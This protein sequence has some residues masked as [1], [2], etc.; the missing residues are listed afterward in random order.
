MLNLSKPTRIHIVGI[1]GAGMSA[2]AVVL[3]S[4]GHEV[5]GSD[6]KDSPGMDRL[7]SLGVKVFVGH[8]QDQ[9]GQ[10]DLVAISS[11]IPD[12]NVEIL[13][14]HSRSIPVLKRAKVLAAISASK[15]TIAVAGT[16]GKTTTSSML[17]LI[18]SYARLKPSFI[19]GGEINEIGSGAAWDEGEWLIIE[20]DE[21]DGT[22]LELGAKLAIVTNIEA[23]HLEFHGS[24]E[25]LVESFKSFMNLADVVVGFADDPII[26]SIE[27][28]STLVTFGLS[29]EADYQIMDLERS[30]SKCKFKLYFKG[31]S[32][33]EVDLPIPGLHNAY[34]ACAALVMSLQ[35]GVDFS[36]AAAALGRFTGVARRFE[37]RGER[38]GITFVDD[39][40]HLPGEI[41]A[42]LSAVADGKW[43][44]VVAVFQ[45][46]RYSRTATLW[47]E[48]GTCFDQADLIVITDVY[49]SGE[50][51]RPGV[52]GKLIAQAVLDQSQHQPSQVSYVPTRPELLSYLRATLSP[53]DICITL[54]AGDITSLS[55]DLLVDPTW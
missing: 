31:S 45:P 8:N 37:L 51:P 33:G 7:R 44:R 10:A 29:K 25:A 26:N 11:A 24:F 52:S 40:G 14:A 2:I 13:A 21:S 47:K 43:D 34:N 12:T 15:K 46:H 38:N 9:I 36:L 5:S 22:F 48:F 49:S 6:L 41:K 30:R 39:Y 53:G 35:I 3:N 54:G 20:A 19:I 23:D 50:P 1:G 27:S 18:L 32:L 16:H 55:D 17:A 4:M 28:T 42:A